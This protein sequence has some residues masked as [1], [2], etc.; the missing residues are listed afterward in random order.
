MI[1][2]TI[3][4]QLIIEALESNSGAASIV[5]ICQYIWQNYESDLRDSGN[6]FYTWQYDLRWASQRLCKEGII[7]KLPQGRMSIWKLC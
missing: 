7:E 6:L 2:K 3:L 1:T 5:K 4:G